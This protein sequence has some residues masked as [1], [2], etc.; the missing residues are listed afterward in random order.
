MQIN[1]PKQNKKKKQDDHVSQ[2]LAEYLSYWP[3]F[4]LSIIACL[5]AAYFYIGYKTPLYEA[6]ASLIIKD[7]KKGN[8]VSKEMESLDIINT[9]KISENEIEVLQSRNIMAS[10]VKDLHLYAVLKK[11]NNLKSASAYSTSPVLIE[12]QHPEDLQSPEKE[13]KRFFF[14]YDPVKNRVQSSSLKVNVEVNNWFESEYGT[15]RF[16]PNPR[17]KNVRASQKMFF[18]IYAVN[19]VSNSLLKALTV[20]GDKLS[21]VINL[22]FKDPSPRRAEDI[23]NG[24]IRFYN[25]SA[26]DEK[27]I[28]VK[29]TLSSLE[30]R[31]RVVR[32]GLDSIEK[33]IEIYKIGTHTPIELNAQGNLYLQN[34]ASN[35]AKY[36]ETKVQLEVLDEAERFVSTNQTNSSILPSAVG[37]NDP[38]LTSM[39]GD[40]SRKQLEKERLKKTVGEGNPIIV[41]LNDEISKLKPAILSNIQNQRKNLN[42]SLNNIA[43]NSGKYNSMLNVIP[44]KEKQLLEISRDQQTKSAIYAFLLQKREESELSYASAISDSRV[45]NYAQ[46]GSR[47]IGAPSI[48]IYLAAFLAGI[49]FP[50]LSIAGREIFSNKILNKR[51]VEKATDMPVI[52]ELSQNKSK[53]HL[54]LEPGMRSFVA[55]EFRKIRIALMYMGIDGIHKKKLLVTSSI[56]GEGKSF[57]ASNLAISLALTGKKVI[58][59]DMDLHNPSL[60]KRFELESSKGISNLLM[61]NA[62]L[63]DVIHTT[64]IPNLDFITA[65][66]LQDNA[67]ELLLNGKIEI[68][69]RSLEKSYDLVIMDTAPTIFVTDA[70]MLTNIAD[71]T[72]YIVR[73]NHTPK[74][75]IKKLDES[76]Q[77]NPLNN[78]AIVFNGVKQIGYQKNNYGYGYNYVYGVTGKEK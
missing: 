60:G 72:L 65:G 17:C 47:P 32:E 26:L 31:L 56:P 30:E 42:S 29:N 70:F 14:N 7:I 8:D 53:K 44:Q 37:L 9:K 19:D 36:G 66:V 50:I 3:A 34:V 46:A 64:N 21:S 25:Q 4:I 12:V 35:D 33:K 45:V 40:L 59:L 57:I 75:V 28:L 22:T 63:T 11:A 23:L 39:I 18:Q 71:G 76:T 5:V 6:N 27:N 10:V 69:I 15:M 78:P 77:I 2:V 67:S 62:E 24:I 74:L 20:K 52:G 68:I 73:Q 38:S 49:A 16:I 51:E 54:V 43:A 41:S 58:L 48:V 1:T 13:A 55:E 61:Q